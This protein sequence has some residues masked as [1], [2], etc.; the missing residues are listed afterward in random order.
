MKICIHCKHY[1]NLEPRSP[2]SYVWYNHTCMASPLPKRV[3]PQ[4][5]FLPRHQ[6]GRRLLEMGGEAM[7]NC[8]GCWYCSEDRYF[9]GISNDGAGFRRCGFIGLLV[10]DDDGGNCKAHRP[11]ELGPPCGVWVEVPE[12]H[13]HGFCDTDCEFLHGGGSGD[14]CSKKWMV[15]GK[16]GKGCPRWKGEGK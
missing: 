2:R 14:W 5:R 4:I 10:N 16:P 13:A 6:P 1:I 7:K 15:E 9:V 8:A 3:S 12:I 11:R